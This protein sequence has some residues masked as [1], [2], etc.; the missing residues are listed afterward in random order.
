[1]LV[2]IATAYCKIRKK[3]SRHNKGVSFVD[4]LDKSVVWTSRTHMVV[5]T[6]N[7]V[8]DNGKEVIINIISFFLEI[9]DEI[10]PI[11]EN[12]LPPIPDD[13]NRGSMTTVVQV[14]NEES[15]DIKLQ[16]APAPLLTRVSSHNDMHE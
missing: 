7:P 10:L 11:S 16:A 2:L 3:K 14:I 12:P 9:Y 6:A 13:N 5:A 4:G 1:M 15:N 8:Y